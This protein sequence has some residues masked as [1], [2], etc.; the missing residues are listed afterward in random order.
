MGKTGRIFLR[1]IGASALRPVAG[2]AL[3]ADGAHHVVILRAILHHVVSAGGVGIRMRI[4]Q[5]RGIFLPFQT[6]IDAIADGIGMFRIRRRAGLPGKDYAVFACGGGVG[7]RGGTE[8]RASQYWRG[9][10]GGSH[11]GLLQSLSDPLRQQFVTSGTFGAGAQGNAEK[12]KHQTDG[13]R[14][15]F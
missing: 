2:Y 8:R 11:I 15:Q 1:N 6:A 12:G 7:R 14:R 9:S 13:E 5:Y 4:E 10:I 3:G